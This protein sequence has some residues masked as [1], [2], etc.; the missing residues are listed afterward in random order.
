V[1]CVAIL[2]AVDEV[3]PDFSQIARFDWPIA[4][5]TDGLW[6]GRSAIRHDEF[7]VPPP[8]AKQNT[9]SAGWGPSGGAAQGLLTFGKMPLEFRRNRCQAA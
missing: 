7:H 2:V 8:N 6:A 5:H 9:V 4:P 1:I 3:R